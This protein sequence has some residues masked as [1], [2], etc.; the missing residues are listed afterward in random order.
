MR[1]FHLSLGTFRSLQ[2][3]LLIA[4]AVALIG[5][6]TIG[7]HHRVEHGTASGW[8]DGVHAEHES[9][10]PE[11]EHHDPVTHDCAALDALALGNGPAASAPPLLF[12]APG[13]T[14]FAFR[15]QPDPGTAALRPFHARAPPPS[16]S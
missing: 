16:L 7:V 5:M 8:I 1:R 11:A 4:V 15:S 13:A 12:S 6:Q 9:A 3:S 14:P 10:G 2:R